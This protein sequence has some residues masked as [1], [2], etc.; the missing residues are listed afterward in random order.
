VGSF[1]QAE[2]VG[3]GDRDIVMQAGDSCAETGEPP[4]W[5]LVDGLA[6]PAVHRHILRLPMQVRSPERFLR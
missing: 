2:A 5:A 3:R 1:P 4:L 6:L